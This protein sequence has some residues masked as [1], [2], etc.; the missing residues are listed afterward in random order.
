MRVFIERFWQDLSRG[1]RMLAKNPAFAAVSVV[2]LAIGV[3]ANAAMFSWADALLL[4]PLPVPRPGE[5]MSVGTKVNLEGFSNLI[6]SYPDYRDLRDNNR[7]FEAL[8][9]FCNVTVGFASQP[10]A[11][12]Q[13][14]LGLAVSGNFFTTM[15]VEPQIGRAFRSEEDQVPGRDA[16]VVLDHS[17]WERQF[18]SDRSILGRPVRLN[19]IDFTVVGIAPESF[20]GMSSTIHPAFYVPLA[21]Y[22]RLTASPRALEARDN[23]IYSVKGRLRPGV[24][25]AQAQEELN[26]F[27]GNLERLYPATNKDQSMAIRTELGIRI[28]QDPIDAPLSAMLLTLSVAVLVV[29]C[30]NVA[31]L[32]TS[33]APARAKEMALRLAVGAGRSLLIRQLLTES[34]LIAVAG[35]LLGILVGYGGVAV[36]RQIQIPTDLPV[37][38]SF[39]LDKRVLFFSLA[40]A[41]F[42]V[43]L[44]GLIPALQTTRVDL[45]GA[46]KTGDTAVAGG[47]RLGGRTVLVAAQVAVSMAL[48]TVATFMYRG[49]HAELSAGQGFRT[50]HLLMMTFDPGLVHYDSSQTDRFYKQ[51]VERTRAVAGVKSV[52]LTSTVPMSVENDTATIVPEGY[53]F[54]KGKNNV[55]VFAARVDENYFDT[56]GIALVRG[57]AFRE[58]DTAGAPRVAIVNEQ[59]AQHYWPGRDAIGKRFQVMDRKKGNPWVEIV[60]I[61]K[62]GKYFW[63]AER[64]TDFVYLPSRQ[65][66]RSRMVLVAESSGDPAALAAPLREA[67]RGLD[68]NLPIFNVRTMAEFFDMRVIATGNTILEVVAGL[69]GMGLILAMVGL[70]GLSSYAVARRTR[71]IGI[72]MAVG[73]SQGAVLGRTL[74]QGLKPALFGLLAGVGLS[75]IAEQM[76]KAVFPAITQADIVSYLLVTPA[77]LAVTL[78]AAFIPARRAARVQP[79]QALRYE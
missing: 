67:V 29:A 77:L 26:A 46:M 42:S 54:P 17:L 32:L 65:S 43:F 70:Y 57:R 60:G 68:S 55:I 28:D 4:R 47:R 35:G 50:N 1:C 20:T 34:L 30:I 66:S 19:G 72:R 2:S 78:L 18:A 37:A 79:V 7:S 63:I 38:L 9:A 11:L 75:A 6:N 23:R 64:P 36:F 73:A 12:P 33:R 49:F 62:T 22:P 10:D 13:M 69:G 14:K 21:M 24:S 61:T 40:V 52:A 74:L 59:F 27:A 41:V 3:G 56:L 25:P 51:V 5:V 45:A 15:D 53:Q 16:V 58:T 44:F 31:S 8:A 48:L 39:D 71:E 76:M